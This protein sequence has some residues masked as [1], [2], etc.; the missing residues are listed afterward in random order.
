[1]NGSIKFGIGIKTAGRPSSTNEIKSSEL[2]EEI[3]RKIIRIEWGEE[4]VRKI[5][6]VE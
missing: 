2:K 4:I 5:T 6:R 1:V 3:M